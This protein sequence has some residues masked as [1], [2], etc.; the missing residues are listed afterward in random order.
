VTAA[1]ALRTRAAR[2][3]IGELARISDAMTRAWLNGLPAAN[4]DMER[5]IR[6]AALE[7]GVDLSTIPVLPPERI[8]ELRERR[9]PK[10]KRCRELGA[11]VAE[12][13][14]QLAA[15][16]RLVKPD[17]PP[18]YDE[19][20]EAGTRALDTDSAGGPPTPAPIPIV[21]RPAPPKVPVVTCLDEHGQPVQLV[22]SE[23]GQAAG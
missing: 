12:L 8:A 10:C 11:R 13:E 17:P 22:A 19:V 15:K 3:R 23:P 4:V 1:E 6:A 14:A 9:R 5:D 18:R 16:S 21:R 2:Y 7:V 20:F